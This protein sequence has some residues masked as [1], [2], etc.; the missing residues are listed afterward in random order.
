MPDILI[1][2]LG[3]AAPAVSFAFERWRE[4]RRDPELAIIHTDPIQSKISTA[5]A[6][7]HKFFPT[8]YADLRVHWH[9]VHRLVDDKKQP[10]LDLDNESA[11]WDYFRGVLQV[12]CEYR[13]AGYRLHLLVAGGRKEMAFYASTAAAALFRETGDQLW[14]VHSPRDMIES[15]MLRIPVGRKVEVQLVKLPV[16]PARLNDDEL[17]RLLNDPQS[18]FAGSLEN[19]LRFLERLTPAERELADVL[20]ENPYLD[21]SALAERLGKQPKTI[22]NQLGKLYNKMVEFVPLNEGS[23]GS[24]KRLLL[25]DLLRG[26]LD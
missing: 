14:T 18:Y 9:E 1:A 25:A 17:Q 4:G 22:E 8:E 24:Q 13:D 11:A 20:Q 2:T 5:L 19:R 16:L 6:R 10:M 23:D 7:L 12:L 15:G 26:L 3:E 21:T